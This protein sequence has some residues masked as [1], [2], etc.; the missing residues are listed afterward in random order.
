MA[1]LLWCVNIYLT[2]ADINPDAEIGEGCLLAHPVGTVIGRCRIGHHVTM[3]G[4][5]GIGGGG[6]SHDGRDD[7]PII[8]NH[9]LIGVR[10]VVMGPVE[11]GDGATI[12]A[13]ALVLHNVPPRETVAG[14]PARRIASHERT[15]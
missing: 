2:G 9:V 15:A 12:G 11:I 10:A 14:V 6:R 4:Q 3:Y 8:G 7:Q 5:A 13:C 1:R